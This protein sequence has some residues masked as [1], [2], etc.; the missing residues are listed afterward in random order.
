MDTMSKMKMN[1][2]FPFQVPERLHTKL[3]M[4]AQKRR[5]ETGES[6]TWSKV[7]REVLEFHFKRT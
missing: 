4:E 5:K 7:L 3:E 1:Q 6:I 2:R